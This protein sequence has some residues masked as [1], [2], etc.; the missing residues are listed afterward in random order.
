MNKIT[1]L[2]PASDDTAS[3]H[4]A[5]DNPFF[6][7]RIDADDNVSVMAAHGGNLPDTVDIDWLID[8]ISMH[9]TLQWPPGRWPTPLYEDS[10]LK[11]LAL[12]LSNDQILP[13]EMWTFVQ[14]ID[15][16]VM[17]AHEGTQC[18]PEHDETFQAMIDELPFT[19]F[20]MDDELEIIQCNQYAH[21]IMGE[22]TLEEV[23]QNFT[24]YKNDNDQEISLKPLIAD[25]FATRRANIFY[26]L[27][28]VS[29]SSAQK[30]D[31]F[32]WAKPF[33]FHADGSVERVVILALG[34]L[35]K[36]LMEE[37]RRARLEAETAEKTKARLLSNVSHEL[38]TPLTAATGFLQL[39]TQ[40]EGTPPETLALINK[41]L[42][43]NHQL[44]R[45]VHD[46]LEMSRIGDGKLERLDADFDFG[47]LIDECRRHHADAAGEKGL[48]FR[49]CVNCELGDV[50]TDKEKIRY[51]LD[52]LLENA[53]RFTT[54]GYVA[55]E[56]DRRGDDIILRIIDTGP[57]ISQEAQ[58]GLFNPMQDDLDYLDG[59]NRGAGLGLPIAGAY[60][61]HL[62]GSISLEST[63]GA[64][65][66]FEVSL[67]ILEAEDSPALQ[68]DRS[69]VLVLSPEIR[70][71]LLAAIIRA[72]SES[73][74]NILRTQPSSEVIGKLQTLV[75]RYR[76]DELHDLLSNPGQ[77]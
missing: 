42:S 27:Y 34:G 43:A 33:S 44:E 10:H 57:G 70:T 20:V 40:I 5:S 49:Y 67:P 4:T 32:I 64:G 58:T 73:F 66:T 11:R 72:D 30:N 53:I 17:L 63:L 39:A 29:D 50:R 28:R 36:G 12:K 26:D 18:A 24:A 61:E 8:S 15:R 7:F 59:A 46:L 13:V 77:A 54:A 25:V 35:Y 76:F 19:V 47:L 38:R 21:A 62:G 68:I 37:V 69:E 75:E 22:P 1:T 48:E 41:A 52:A 3:G 55:L 65:S 23:N 31:L 14:G 16:F 2:K 60:V 45:R 9:G 74:S 6:L 56:I 71:E 51:V